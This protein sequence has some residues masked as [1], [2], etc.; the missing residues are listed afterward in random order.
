MLFWKVIPGYKLPFKDC[1]FSSMISV[2]DG[3]LESFHTKF[4]EDNHKV[5]MIRLVCT[6][7]CLYVQLKQKKYWL[8]TMY[9]YFGSSL[10]PACLQI[11]TPGLI[12]T[13]SGSV[14]DHLLQSSLQPQQPYPISSGSNRSSP[15]TFLPTVLSW[16]SPGG[17]DASWHSLG[18][19]NN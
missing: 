15:P 10:F 18:L 14:E 2:V 9:A 13:A 7:F 3:K 19:A 1:T 8:Q 4:C 16:H 5:C 6:Y 11:Q 12:H 17:I